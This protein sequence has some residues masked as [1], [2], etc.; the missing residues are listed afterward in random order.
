[1]KKLLITATLL[2]MISLKPLIAGV[3]EGVDVKE[4]Q[5]HLTKLCFN[6]G[7]ID[8]LWGKKTENAAKQFLAGQNKTFSGT[9]TKDNENTLWGVVNARN[10]QASFGT[11]FVKLCKVN[12]SGEVVTVYSASVLIPDSLNSLP[13]DATFGY[14]IKRQNSFRLRQPTHKVSPSSSPKFFKKAVKNHPLIKQQLADTPMLS[15]L[16]YDNGVVVHDA[17]VAK[18]RFGFSIDDNTYFPSHSMGK[19]VTSYLIGH[20][21]CQ[22]YISSIDAHLDDWPLMKETLYF[23]QPLINLLN[24]K[25][26]D[27]EVLEEYGNNFLKSGRSIHDSPLILAIQNPLELKNTKPVKFPKFSYSN[28]TSNVLFNYLMFKVGSDFETFIADFYQNKVRSERPVYHGM[29]HNMNGRKSANM[30]ERNQNLSGRY[31]LYATRYDFLRIAVAIME[32]WQNDTCEGKYLKE[33]YKR[34]V[35]SRRNSSWNTKFT[36]GGGKPE[37]SQVASKYGGQ[38]HSSFSGLKGRQILG[39][40]GYNGQTILIDMDNSR[41]LVI[42]AIK[43]NHHDTYKLGYEPIKYGRIR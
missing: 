24:M 14:Y 37:F 3:A 13:N 27:S 25:A 28:L 19:S 40:A 12:Q 38:F 10:I 9:F 43:S 26:G 8:G 29:N 33:V 11:G 21:I 22:G 31:D 6:A 17:V 39:M 35:S 34:R 1:M 5:T 32:D 18:E 30:R 2:L 42:A 41:I 23:G 15:Y 16:F 20:A 36:Y 7:P 4:V